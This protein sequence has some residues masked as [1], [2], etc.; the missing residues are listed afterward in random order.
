MAVLFGRVVSRRQ[1]YVI[2]LCLVVSVSLICYACT[3]YI[4]YRVV[5]LMLLLTVSLT[6]ISFDILPVLFTATLSAFVWDFFFIPPRFALHVDTT[7]DAI[8]LIMYFIIALINAVLTFKIRQI[9]K[10]ARQREERANAIKLYNAFLNSLSHELRTPIAA[11]IGATDNLQANNVNLTDGHKVQLIAEISK[12]SLRLN[13]QVENLLNMSRLESGF[14]KPR[15]DWCDLPELMHETVKGIEENPIRQSIHIHHEPDL[16]LFRLDK[17]MM[18]QIIYNLIYNACLHTPAGTHITVTAESRA[19]ALKLVIQ[20][21]GEGFPEEEIEFVF[22]KFYRVRQST[23]TGTG[24]GLSIVKG[25][26]EA[27]GGRIHLQN[28]TDGGCRFSIEMPAET[29]YLKV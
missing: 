14:L 4:G 10:L 29:S 13:Q 8:L 23:T 17:G 28:M 12:A 6:A 27:L 5:A 2:S 19:G 7:D 1:Q 15:L 25:F 20:D 18:Q 22:D 26:T 3:D 21:D 11:I 16:P 9:E 24:L